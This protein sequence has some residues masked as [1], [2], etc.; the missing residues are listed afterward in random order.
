MAALPALSSSTLFPEYR[1]P[2]TAALATLRVPVDH[3]FNLRHADRAAA[4]GAII[5]HFIIGAAPAQCP[6]L[7]QNDFRSDLCISIPPVNTELPPVSAA[8]RKPNKG[9]RAVAKHL[10][11]A[12]PRIGFFFQAHASRCFHQKRPK[13]CLGIRSASGFS[14]E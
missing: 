4:I 7:G 1:F 9:L 13:E 8:A 2:L 6:E 11:Q 3:Q 5:Q 12:R 10:Q 14:A